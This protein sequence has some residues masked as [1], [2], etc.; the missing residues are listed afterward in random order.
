MGEVPFSLYSVLISNTE[1]VW[2][3][4][5]YILCYLQSPA[6]DVCGVLFPVFC[7]CLQ[8]WMCASSFYCILCTNDGKIVRAT[9]TCMLIHFQMIQPTLLS[10]IGQDHLP[11][12]WVIRRE[13]SWNLCS[14]NK[15]NDQRILIYNIN[16]QI[17]NQEVKGVDSLSTW[18]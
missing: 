6:L 17:N 10:L 4:L 2:I 9:S 13:F 5:V 3:P 15:R 7:V 11:F 16:T 1:Y 8:H 14:Q 12:L 18:D